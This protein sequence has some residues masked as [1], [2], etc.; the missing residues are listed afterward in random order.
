M[1]GRHLLGTKLFM[2]KANTF[3]FSRVETWQMWSKANMQ[4]SCLNVKHQIKCKPLACNNRI[5]TSDSDIQRLI[6]WP[7]SLCTAA[8]VLWVNR[9]DSEKKFFLNL[10]WSMLC[11][12]FFHL[13]LLQ[14]QPPLTYVYWTWAG[15][16]SYPFEKKNKSIISFNVTWMSFPLYHKMT[17]HKELICNLLNNES[18]PL[19]PWSV[20][21]F[22]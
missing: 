21:Y 11:V 18:F 14:T 16:I 3:Q 7:T 15:N 10:M 1:E 13:S 22:F 19:C 4:C 9:L 8:H 2:N 20:L 17:N 12:V 5:L 6:H